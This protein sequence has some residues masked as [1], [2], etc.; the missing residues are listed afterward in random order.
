MRPSYYE[1]LLSLVVDG[2]YYVARGRDAGDRTGSKHRM[3]RHIKLIQRLDEVEREM[4][5]IFLVPFKA[6]TG[7]TSGAAQKAA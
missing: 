5:A 3:A 6:A 7:G 2:S 1:R 4:E